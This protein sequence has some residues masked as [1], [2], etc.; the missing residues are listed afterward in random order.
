MVYLVTLSV[1]QHYIAR[2]MKIDQKV[3]WSDQNNHKI[4]LSGYLAYGLRL[5]PK[6]SQI[7]STVANNLIVMFDKN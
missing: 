5:E 7:E 1:T 6:N 2:A 4:P 3:C